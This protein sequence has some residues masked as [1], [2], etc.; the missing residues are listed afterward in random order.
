MKIAVLIG[1]IVSSSLAAPVWEPLGPYTANCYTLGVSPSNNDIIYVAGVAGDWKPPIFRTIDGG[2]SWS[3]ISI[4]DHMITSVYSIAVTP[5]SPDTLYVAVL[6]QIVG[7]A[8]LYK[9]T[10]A[11]A[12]WNGLEI[13]RLGYSEYSIID[14]AIHPTVPTTV[15]AAGQL[16]RIVGTDTSV[17]V[18]FFKSTD[19]GETWADTI[20][21]PDTCTWGA[22]SCVR[23]DPSNPDIIYV[24]GGHIHGGPKHAVIYKSTD[25]GSTFTEKSSG[26]PDGGAST[27][28][29]HPTNA[30]I[31]YTGAGQGVY[32]ST[33]GGDSW[34]QVYSR[35]IACLATSPADS[36]IVYGLEVAHDE[37]YCDV[38]HKSTD[39]GMSWSETGPGIHGSGFGYFPCTNSMEARSDDA[40]TVYLSIYTGFYK[41]ANGG[42]DWYESIEGMEGGL[43]VLSLGV[44]PSLPTVIYTSG[45]DYDLEFKSTNSGTDWTRLYVNH[46][47]G[48]RSYAV[49]NANPDIVFGFTGDT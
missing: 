31:V 24:G 27:V 9:S 41:T 12:T 14:L 40:N 21:D 2:E 42:T 49:H 8:Y 15:F 17:L 45:W 6:P 7:D 25:G 30:S 44:A 35:P 23:L 13:T 4:I 19:G 16:R 34:S 26:L 22:A 47:I 33:D 39:A 48:F 46:D 36:D 32:R 5:I 10:D 28:A 11:G 18:G 38:V 20:L 43:W 29:V 37:M 1:L 3:E